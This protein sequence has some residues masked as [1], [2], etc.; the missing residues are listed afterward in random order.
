MQGWRIL[1]WVAL[2]A[3]GIGFLWLVRGVLLPFVVS[4]VIAAILEPGVRKL[5]LKGFSRRAAVYTVLTGFFGAV[6]AIGVIAVPTMARQ[7]AGVSVQAQELTRFLTED[8]A[9]D[10]F[11]VRWNPVVISKRGEGPSGQIDQL[12]TQY[13]P[14]LERFGIPSTRRGLIDQYVDRNRP[15]IAA[16]VQGVFDSFFGFA[17]GILS[18]A[19]VVILVPLIVTMLLLEMDNFRRRTPKWIPPSIRESTVSVMRDVGDVFFSYLRGISLL[20]LYFTIAQTIMLTAAGLPY[21]I[22]LGIVFGTFY[23]IPIFGNIISSVCI[24]LIIGM[25]GVTGNALFD[26]GNPWLYGLMVAALYQSIGGM[27]DTFVAPRTVGHSVGLSP[28]MSIF[29]VMSGQALFGL[30]GMIV[31]FPLAGAIK[32]ILDRLFRLTSATQESLA[33]PVVPLRHRTTV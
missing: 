27:F 30:P 9:N 8:G 32:V 12:L 7:V 22:L 17:T 15:K 33:L 24:F 26:V 31:A 2:V 16:W 25:T 20:I 1:L 13:G 5:R 4:V 6:L 3:V 29:V 19:F 11:F 23:L 21:A 10:N 14:T 28:L 18:Q